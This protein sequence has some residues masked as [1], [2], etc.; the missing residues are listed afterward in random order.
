[1]R[2]HRG[3]TL[4]L[5]GKLGSA[6]AA[7]RA[8]LARRRL[9]PSLARRLTCLPKWPSAPERAAVSHHSRADGFRGLEMWGS[10]L[11]AHQWRGH[12]AASVPH[13]AGGAHL[14]SCAISDVRCFSPA[15]TVN[16]MSTAPRVYDQEF[17]PRAKQQ[18]ARACRRSSY[19]WCMTTCYTRRKRIALSKP[20]GR[21]C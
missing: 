16:K 12:S 7:R 3:E 9:W 20:P 15:H 4:L 19:T 18:D 10:V 1:M 13:R 17:L 5:W 8:L 6:V 14:P 21:D 11:R 2:Q